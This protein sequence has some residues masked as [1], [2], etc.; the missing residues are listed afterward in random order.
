MKPE[1]WNTM[2]ITEKRD[3][4]TKLFNSTRGQLIIGQALA[5]ATAVMRTEEYPE[6]S[7][8][9]DMEELGEA[10]FG[11]WYSLYTSRV[12]DSVK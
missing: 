9:E 7:N 2:T 11:V 5:R 3:D 6:T 4:A 10:L 1:N 12:L 8:I